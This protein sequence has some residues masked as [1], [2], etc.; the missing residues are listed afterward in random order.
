MN[1]LIFGPTQ[2]FFSCDHARIFIIMK[3]FR[4]SNGSWCL[5]NQ[6]LTPLCV[7]TAFPFVYI[8]AWPSLLLSCISVLG[9][10]YFFFIWL[11]LLT[12]SRPIRCF[13]DYIRTG[14]NYRFCNGSNWPARIC[15]YRRRFSPG[16]NSTHSQRDVIRIGIIQAAARDLDP[17]R[18]D[19]G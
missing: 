4:L 3:P 19:L 14:N 9:F 10:Q 11:R 13:P 18:V 1:F 2:N 7:P 12:N 8:T 6:M 15:T 16:Q 17:D 5:P